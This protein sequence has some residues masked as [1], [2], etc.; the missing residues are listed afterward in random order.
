MRLNGLPM[1]IQSFKSRRSVDDVF[2]F[3][4]N[5]WRGRA[6]AECTRTHKLNRHILGIKT[7][8]YYISIEA[9][10]TIQGTEGTITVSPDLA[11]GVPK[12]TTRFPRSPAAAVVNLQEYED[13]GAT[14]EY[15]SMQSARA[16]VVEV[17][18][19]QSLL[20]RDGWS[21]TLDRNAEVAPGGHVLEAQRG[22]EQ[23]QLTFQPMHANGK[24]SITVIWKKS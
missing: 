9:R 12:V 21:I 11:R 15:I 6:M 16:V 4:E 8:D 14:A 18:E 13:G 23:A 10:T 17:S 22:A 20:A 1:T 24:T 3:Y 2:N 19:F 5:E 7:A